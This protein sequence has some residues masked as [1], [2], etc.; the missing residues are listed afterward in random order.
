MFLW[1]QLQ[2]IGWLNT[3]SDIQ[4]CTILNSWAKSLL[5]IYSRENWGWSF[6][7]RGEVE[8]TIHENE[9]QDIQ[10]T[11]TTTSES[12]AETKLCLRHCA[13]KKVY[14]H[15][16]YETAKATL[17][18]ISLTKFNPAYL[19]NISSYEFQTRS[20]DRSNLPLK[21]FFLLQTVWLV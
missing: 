9:D 2:T 15:E 8:G 14:C 10:R 20:N 1:D 13:V 11:K 4:Y 7:W 16:K 17:W 6:P 21:N 18:V 19:M 12:K 5:S 3:L